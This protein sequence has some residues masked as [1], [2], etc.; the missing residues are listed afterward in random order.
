MEHQALHNTTDILI[1]V[2]CYRA[3]ESHLQTM[4]DGRLNELIDLHTNSPNKYDLNISKDR[5]TIFIQEAI[6]RTL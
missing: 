6:R 4:T 1:E 5:L 3:Y 2:G